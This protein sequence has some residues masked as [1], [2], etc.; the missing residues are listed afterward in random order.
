MGRNKVARVKPV[1]RVFWDQVGTFNAMGAAA[2]VED[3]ASVDLITA[4]EVEDLDDSC[5]VKRIV[6]EVHFAFIAADGAAA[7]GMEWYRMGLLVEDDQYANTTMQLSSAADA[8]DAPW[9][10]LRTYFGGGTGLSNE[11]GNTL[12]PGGQMGGVLSTHID[13]KVARRLRA[14]DTLRLKQ[15][16][17]AETVSWLCRYNINLRILL[18]A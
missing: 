18:E 8:Q 13:I 9:L 7:L 15:I 17:R 2:G 12:A 14:G 6:G 10:F 3:N 5:L 1:W 4:A 16:A 11:G